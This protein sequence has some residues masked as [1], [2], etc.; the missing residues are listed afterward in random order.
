M[1]SKVLCCPE[2][3]RRGRSRANFFENLQNVTKLAMLVAQKKSC[4][5]V[6][7]VR[8]WRLKFKQITIN[9]DVDFEL[10]VCRIWIMS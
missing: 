4:L 9:D 8:P 6:T 7:C 1:D 2:I 10:R 5:T 3:R